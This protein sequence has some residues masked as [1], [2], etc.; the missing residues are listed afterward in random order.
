MKAP[1]VLRRW[2]DH[3]N[4]CQERCKPS[5]K[6]MGNY[7]PHNGEQTDIWSGG[8]ECFMVNRQVL[9]L[10]VDHSPN[11]EI[12]GHGWARFV[13][14]LRLF[15]TFESSDQRLHRQTSSVVHHINAQRLNWKFSWILSKENLR[16]QRIIKMVNYFY[17]H[18]L[19]KYKS[20]Q[21]KCDGLPSSTFGF[22][23]KVVFDTLDQERPILASW[24]FLYSFVSNWHT[25]VLTTFL[26]SEMFFALSFL[27]DTQ[28]TVFVFGRWWE[29]EEVDAEVNGALGTFLTIEEG[30][31]GGETLNL[32]RFAVD[33]EGIGSEV[34]CMGM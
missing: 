26:S 17:A 28:E 22:M 7:P 4:L 23:G 10:S 5:K 31:F 14:C 2:P 20:C 12:Y 8:T 32:E 24:V 16:H 33:P 3:F 30:A 9:L 15:V 13:P 34:A 25:C 29:E 18:K 11:R 19:I 21:V 27:S 1:A 6:V